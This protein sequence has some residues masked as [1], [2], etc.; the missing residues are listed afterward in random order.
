MIV[1]RYTESLKDSWNEFIRKAKNAT[2][3]FERDYMDYHSSRFEDYSLVVTNNNK[4]I[5]VVPANI[6]NEVLYSHQGLSYGGIVTLPNVSFQESLN[7]YIIVFDHLYS[8]NIQTIHLKIIP[9]FYSI[10]PSDEVDYFM[11]QLQ[12]KKTRCDVTLAIN[13]QQKLG[14]SNDKR[15]NIASAK[16]KNL[17]ISQSTDYKSFWKEILIPNLTNTHGV[18]PVHSAE[19]I[20][21]LHRKFP[22]N[23]EWFVATLD[24]RIVGGTVIFISDNVAH[25]QYISANQE[26]KKT[27]ALEL[28]H[29]YL[30]NEKFNDK[31]IFDFGIVNKDKGINKGLTY[32]KEGFGARTYCHDFYEVKTANTNLL[33][34][35]LI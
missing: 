17:Q 11:H 35:I 27:G 15:K 29:N 3:L 20:Q 5:A 22:Q 21:L 32:W 18:A 28:L 9:S 16:K 6:N 26:G 12:A 30:I 7:I 19:E 2:F 33:K 14:L 31:N 25:S 4:F 34:S 10:H 8:I 1:Q 13:Q 24:D 23:I